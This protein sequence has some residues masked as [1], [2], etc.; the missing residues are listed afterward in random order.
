M[1]LIASDLLSADAEAIVNASNRELRLGGGVSGAIREAAWPSLQT[2]LNRMAAQRV[3]QDGDCVLTAAHGLP[4]FGWIIHAVAATGTSEVVR[5]AILNVLAICGE[6]G[7]RSVA[8]PALGAGAGGMPMEECARVFGETLSSLDKPQGP[9][10]SVHVITR[11]DFN[12]FAHVFQQ[13]FCDEAE[14]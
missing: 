5:R 2:A 10:V 14:S 4:R 12:T 7:I 6:H 3:L 8:F 9:G 13:C 11:S 1:E